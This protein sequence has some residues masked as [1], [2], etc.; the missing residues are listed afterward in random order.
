MKDMSEYGF[1]EISRH[2]LDEE[3]LALI[4]GLAKSCINP[5]DY[6]TKEEIDKFICDFHNYMDLVLTV[7]KVYTKEMVDYKL[8][9]ITDKID[10]IGSV[11]T[12]TKQEINNMILSLKNEIGKKLDKGSVY[13]KKEVQD[14]INNALTGL[15]PDLSNYYTK[16]EVDNKLDGFLRKEDIVDSIDQAHTNKAVSANQIS[17]LNQKIESLK[18]RAS[19]ARTDIAAAITSVGVETSSNDPWETMRDNILSLQNKKLSPDDYEKLRPVDNTIEEL[20]DLTQY[21]TTTDTLTS[22]HTVRMKYDPDRDCYFVVIPDVL[23]QLDSKF[24][25]IKQLPLEAR[26]MYNRKLNDLIVCKNYIYMLG[27]VNNRY[28]IVCVN[29]DT[30]SI[31][32]TL[33]TFTSTGSNHRLVCK[34]IKDNRIIVTTST[35]YSGYTTYTIP[36]YEI[37]YDNNPT[38]KSNLFA[39]GSCA[40]DRFCNCVGIVDDSVII[41]PL[42]SPMVGGTYSVHPAYYPIGYNVDG[43]L[44]LSSKKGEVNLSRA[45]FDYMYKNRL[46]IEKSK[47]AIIPEYFMYVDMIFDENFTL[48][49]NMMFDGVSDVVYG[50]S[51]SRRCMYASTS[52]RSL[53]TIPVTHYRNS[54]SDVENGLEFVFDHTNKRVLFIRNDVIYE[55]NNTNIKIYGIR[56]EEK[57][58]VI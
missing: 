34:S 38:L 27:R 28:T 51:M 19:G 22:Y 50:Y 46:Y 10:G 36:V 42:T 47:Q 25:V 9:L 16:G 43:N 58:G 3:L 2:E 13:T 31:V 30:F 45:A 8:G 32:G 57:D 15:M 4:E 18:S 11:D 23:L 12:Y 29:I 49:R 44:E 1:G 54:T 40:E 53:W 5:D 6:Y 37:Y 56:L 14:L 21:I 24:K 48:G 7:D 33:D 55:A 39:N 17:I 35:I 20:A 52:N 41:I 26:F